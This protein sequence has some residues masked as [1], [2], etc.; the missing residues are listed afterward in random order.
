MD[1]IEEVLLNLVR[2]LCSDSEGVM[3]K[4]MQSMSDDEIILYV[5]APSSDLARL[6]GKKGVMAQSLRVMMQALCAHKKLTIQFE[7]I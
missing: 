7:A 6:S 1:N 3:V 4:R 2:P 5:Y